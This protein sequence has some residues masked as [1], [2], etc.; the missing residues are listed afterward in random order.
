VYEIL[1][2]N[3]SGEFG[4]ITLTPYEGGRTEVDIALVG[5]P[6]E[7]LQPV[8]VY[9]GS[10]AKLDPHPRYILNYAVAG[11]SQTM[12]AVQLSTLITGGF[13]INVHKSTNDVDTYVACGTLGHKK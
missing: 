3:H 7:E 8:N 10:C 4:T 11:I 1:A 9:A 6:G 2:Q 5:A 13:S 12:L